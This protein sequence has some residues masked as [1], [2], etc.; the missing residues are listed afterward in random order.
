MT[1]EKHI[2]LHKI[3]EAQALRIL[4]K[5]FRDIGRRISF[6][7]L[8]ESNAANLVAIAVNEQKFEKALFKL[9]LSIGL[10]AGE[11]Q[12]QEF[13]VWNK[14]KKRRKPSQYPLFSKV[15]QQYLLD[16]YNSQ[17]GDQI[18]T[19]TETYTQA[20][21]NE[22]KKATDEAITADAIAERMRKVVNSPNFYKWQALRIART[23]TTFAVG[24]ATEVTKEYSL[25]E[26][27]KVW[28]H[29]D[30][31]GQRDSHAAMNGKTVGQKE[32]FEIDG[33]KL[34]YPGDRSNGAT[35]RNLINCMCRR[36]YRPKKDANGDWI[37]KL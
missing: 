35:A 10:K 29:L 22:L 15:F 4:L 23:E 1:P 3:Y 11:I 37:M 31:P 14:N 18:V 36:G 17:G 32:L 30:R 2:A 13:E 28:I 6:S 16:Y 27:E 7:V 12:L 24:A 9:H 8:T 33:E 26:V 5:E 21:I 20:V 19:L 25:F 34:S